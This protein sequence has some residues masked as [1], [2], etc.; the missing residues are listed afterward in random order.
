MKNW[1][2]FLKPN[3]ELGPNRMRLA[4][5]LYLDSL[6]FTGKYVAESGAQGCPGTYVDINNQIMEDGVSRRFVLELSGS[7]RCIYED[8]S[9]LKNVVGII[10]V[11][12]AAT[13]SL[14]AETSPSLPFR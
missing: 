12:A 7:R 14:K 5:C 2:G 13:A 10:V 11:V 6:K 3:F 9:V 4:G 8:L 1:K